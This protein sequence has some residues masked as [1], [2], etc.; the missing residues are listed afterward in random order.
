MAVALG[1]IKGKWHLKKPLLKAEAADCSTSTYRRPLFPEPGQ[2]T[3]SKGKQRRADPYPSVPTPHPGPRLQAEPSWREGP[4]APRLA[5]KTGGE[6]NIFH[7][8]CFSIGAVL[9][10]RKPKEK[11]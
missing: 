9:G 10:N 2:Q 11:Y 7:S 6:G 8:T 5:M 1:K 3:G 4:H